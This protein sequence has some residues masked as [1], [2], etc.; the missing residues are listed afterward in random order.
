MKKRLLITLACL[1]ILFGAIFGWKAFYSHKRSEVA[2]E[3]IANHL[4]AVSA[5]QAKESTWQPSLSSVGSTRT[6]KGIY[7][8]TEL[9][10][11]I[12]RIDF[13]PGAVVQKG[14]LL[15]QLDIAPD[16]AKL[17][18][19]EA[20]ARFAKVTYRRNLKQYR[21]GAVSKQTLTGDEAKYQ[22]TKANVAQEQAIIAK[23]TIR[24][25]FSGRL[26]IALVYP[27]QYIN[28]GDKVVNLETLSPIYV[29]FYLPQQDL[30][31]VDR[32][33]FCL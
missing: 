19:L 11:M 12:T 13:K 9:G 29:D 3:R 4:A 10:G 33:L 15:A 5:M 17:H 6:Y 18:A 32:A 1:A 23:K 2:K 14:Q 16:V 24:A 8:T 27:G 26:G 25:P 21:I 20:D 28:P 22:S 31:E 30:T 7:V